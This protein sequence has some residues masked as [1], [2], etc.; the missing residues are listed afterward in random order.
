M[1][2]ILIN[3]PDQFPAAALDLLRT[4]GPVHLPGESFAAESIE[5]IFVRLAQRLDAG[6]TE[7]YPKLRFIVS[8]TTGLNHIDQ[9][10]FAECGVEILSLCGRTEFLESIRATAEHTLA[11]ALALIRHV[12]QAA[13]HTRDGGWDRYLFKGTELHGKRVL[14]I[15]YGRIGRQV[16]RLY[17]A[18]GCE[19][20]AHDVVLGKVPPHLHFNYPADLAQTDLLSIHVNLT[21]ETVGLVDEAVLSQLPSHAFVINT[22]RGE[23]VD[24]V[25]LLRL[26]K[27][28]R[29]AGAALDVL[30]GEPKP[31]YDEAAKLIAAID[32]HRLLITPH[33]SGFTEE[34]LEKV[35]IHMAQALVYRLRQTGAETAGTAQV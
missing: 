26:L 35:E 14:L 29:L 17:G 20:R 9:K 6:L 31:F 19:V 10:H 18:F 24:Q 12:P 28:G 15:G 34:S 2:A 8:P 11:L 21:H 25:A 16:E 5:A 32:E 3:E 23:I 4:Q 7:R 1:T 13:K 30:Y 33:I 27:D 22:S